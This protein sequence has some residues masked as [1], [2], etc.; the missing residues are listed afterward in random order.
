MKMHW[1]MAALAL[2]LAGCGTSVVEQDMRIPIRF[3]LKEPGFVTLVIEDSEGVRVR[4]LISQEAFPAGDHVVLWD[5]MDDKERDLDAARHAI[6]HIPGR[7]VQAG[8]YTVRGLVHPGIDL[9]YEMTPYTEGKPPWRSADPGSQWLTNHSSPSD[10]IFLPAGVSPERE[11]KPTSAGG[12]LLVCSRVAEGGSGLAWLDMDGRKLW[13]QHWLGGVWTAAS[14]LALD[15]GNNPVPGTYAYAAASWPGDK[16][17]DFK[18]ELRLHRMVRDV[19]GWAKAPKDKRFGVGEDRPVLT[20]TWTIPAVDGVKY[21]PKDDKARKAAAAPLTGLAV[22]N[23]II[24]CAFEKLNTLLLVDGHKDKVARTL[25]IAAP[26]GVAF[27]RSGRLYV[28]SGDGVFRYGTLDAKPERFALGLQDPQN[29]LIAD[30]GKWYISDWGNSHQVK[31]YSESGKALGAIGNAGAPALGKYDTNHMNHPAGMALD[32]RGRLWVT[33]NTHIPK[34]VSVWDTRTGA[35]LNGLYGPMRYGGSGA[36]DPADKTRFFYD[37]DHGGTIEFRL[38]YET[39]RST[40]LAIPYL[41]RYNKTGLIGRYVGAAPG[42]PLRNGKFLYLT[43]TY[44]LATS[45]RRT[46]TL[47]RYDEDSIL[48]IVAAAGG[49]LDS[50]GE[51]LPVF[52]NNPAMLERM[53][54]GFVPGKGKAL[55]FIWSDRNG[56][57][58]VDPAEVEFLDPNTYEKSNNPT[59]GTVSVDSDLAFTFSD[60]G[61]AVLQFRPDSITPKGVPF[62]SMAARKVLATGAQ[63][64]ASSGG[65]QVLTA[66]DGWIVTTTPLKPFAREGVAG[67]RNGKPIW[68]YPSL[69]PGLHASHIAPMPENPGQLI[70][71][72]RVIGNVID[73]P[74]GSDAGQLWAINANKGTIYVFTVD[75]L[76]VTRL[77]QDSR[78]I[79]WNAPEAIRGMNVNH[80]SL[81]EECFGP[82]WT[83]L[84]SGEVMLQAHFVGSI[85]EVKNLDKIRRLPNRTI[86]VDAGMLESAR[87]WTVE[88]EAERQ[89]ESAVNTAPLA[90]P[91]LAKAPV[92][93]GDPA[94]WGGEWILIDRRTQKVGNWGKKPIETRAK[95]A[96]GPDGMLYAA[97]RVQDKNLLNSS[98]ESLEKLFKCGGALDLMLGADASA[99]PARRKPVAGDR[100]LLVTR[101]KGKELMAALYSPVDPASAGTKVEFGSPLRTLYFDRVESVGDRI[102]IAEKTQKDLKADPAGSITITTYEL[103]IPLSLF[104]LVPEPGMRLKFDAGILRGD[105]QQTLQR[106]YWNNK[107]SGMVSDIPSEAELIPALW[108]TLVFEK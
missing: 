80:L 106:V 9:I 58:V 81:Q 70:G 60:V 108:G 43:D 65:N 107:R 99:D 98:G 82:L 96:V 53:P 67:A 46:A 15:R 61:G 66:K 24:V 91:F 48:R 29:I 17:N 34:R 4:N 12:Q 72:T 52:Q 38:D 88:R 77:F 27:D 51:V 37:D 95:F 21:D 11:G 31:I 104:G 56:D 85:I 63:R 100:R 41:E 20:P 42:Y 14:H 50:A 45:G 8:R 40:P 35:L 5:G 47:W 87:Q 59:T 26:R 44:G 18:N 10:V 64:P 2:C 55:L 23:G 30:D 76:F 16:Y 1:G 71:T 97:W 68:Y 75:G 90:V 73:A 3:S 94:D 7:L 22:Y 89:R 19:K 13:G 33:E 62:Y 57:Q 74:P 92:L 39:G 69:W 28:L 86:R 78:T 83:R 25:D 102:R 84:D 79:S 101:A 103:A 36:V 32:D 54:R 93:D 49:I 105:G 6:F